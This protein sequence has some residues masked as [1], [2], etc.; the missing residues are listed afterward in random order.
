MNQFE[1][2]IYLL[3]MMFRFLGAKMQWMLV[4]IPL[5]TKYWLLPI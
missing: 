4:F 5:Q 1:K 2:E 3:M